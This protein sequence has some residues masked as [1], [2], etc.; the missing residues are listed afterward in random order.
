MIAQLPE[1]QRQ[2]FLL[3]QH[4]ELKFREI[5]ELREEPLSTVLGHMHYALKK[6]KQAVKEHHDDSA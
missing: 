5:A 4:G 1:K 6:L 3:R 2:V